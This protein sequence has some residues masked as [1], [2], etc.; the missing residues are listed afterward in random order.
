MFLPC[1]VLAPHVFLELYKSE[2]CAIETVG[3]AECDLLECEKLM[4]A[5]AALACHEDVFP[6]DHNRVYQTVSADAQGKIIQLFF[7]KVLALPIFG[8]CYVGYRDVAAFITHHSVVPP[9]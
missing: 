8:N 2:F 7:V 9:D 1:Q 6:S 4:G 5:E 3:V